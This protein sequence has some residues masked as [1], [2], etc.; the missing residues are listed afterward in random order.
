MRELREDTFSGN[1]NED[2]HDHV[3]R[4]LSIKPSTLGTSLKKPL[5]KAI[6]TMDNHSQKWHEGSSS[7][8]INNSSD[9]D[10]LVAA[11]SKLDNLGRDMKKLKENVHAIQVGCRLDFN[12][13]L[14]DLR[15][16]ISIM[17]FSMFKRLGT[18]KLKPINMIIEMA[19]A[20]KCI[21]KGIVKNLLI[22][23]DKFILLID[24]VILDIIEDFRML[25]ILGRSLL[26][27]THAK[28]DI[29][30]KTMSSEIGNEKVIF[31]MRSNFSNKIKEFVRMINTKMKTED[32]ELMKIDSDLFTYNINSGKANYLLFI[33]P[34]VFTYDI[35]DQESYEEIVYK[36]PD[37]CGDSKE[38]EIIGTILNKLHDEWFK[39]TYEDDDDL[40]RII[41]YLEPT[42]YDK[43][44]DSD[45]K[46]TRKGIADYYECLT[47]N[48]P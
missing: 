16:S 17:T 5:S 19:D 45:D 12:D 7:R 42:L 38:N 4:V 46:N 13:A 21:P 27:T 29:F 6:Q 35:E 11:I 20:T 48:Y 34:D 31:K 15:A 24:F 18:G 40:E 43:F 32:D 26:A 30:Q 28:V 44:V 37:G 9:T 2:A 23:M 41:D 39:G 22:K 47:S 33:N 14:A 36:Y 25:V 1:K 10:G 8:N 3:D